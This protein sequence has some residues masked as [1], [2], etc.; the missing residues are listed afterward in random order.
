[1]G[2]IYLTIAGVLEIGFTTAMRYTDSFTKL[3]PS[4]LVLVLAAASV[5]LVTKSAETIPLGTAYVAWGG[6]GAIGTVVIGILYF[7]E[8][9]TFWRL[10]F[11]AA[12]ILCIAGLKLVTE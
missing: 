3:L 2:W 7:N 12:L 9:V 11:L 4:L 5:F 10:F 1:M 8:P 6:I